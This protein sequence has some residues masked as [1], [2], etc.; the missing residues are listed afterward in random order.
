M[1][2]KQLEKG[3]AQLMDE[4]VAQLFVN[5][6]NGRK[7]IL[8]GNHDYWW[9]TMTKL[10]EFVKKN[11]YNTISFL[12]NNAYEAEGISICGTR[13]WLCPGCSG[14]KESSEKYFNREVARLEISLKTATTD[15]KYVFT[16]Y[17][18]MSNM[19]QC[20]AFV[21][22]MKKYNVKKCFY[23]H[24]HGKSHD[25]RLSEEYD[26]IKYFLVSSDFLSFMPKRI[27]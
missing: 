7:I 4:G 13:G 18:P 10:D 6:F 22:M 26:G 19:Y 14:Y 24:L 21:D 5:Q 17:P 15:E 1:K 9:T 27:K 16:H 12:H 2:T 20:N 23:G 3:I 25:F 8:K 11:G